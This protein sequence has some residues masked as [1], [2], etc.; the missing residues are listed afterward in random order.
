MIFKT[1]EKRH[2]FTKENYLKTS[3]THW[4]HKVIIKMKV[5]NQTIWFQVWDVILL[6]KT[7]DP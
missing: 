6:D 1:E 5:N 3:R 7:S 4:Q 2:S